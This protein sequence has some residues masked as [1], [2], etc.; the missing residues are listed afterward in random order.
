MVNL[1]SLVASTVAQPSGWWAAIYN[2]IEG[3]IVNY[4]WTILVFTVFVRLIMLPLDFY[5]RYSSR[6]NNFIQKR[7]AGQVQRINEKNKNNQQKAN[8]EVQA[9]YKKEGYNMVGTC[10]FSII[11]IV[12][13]LFVFISFFNTLRDISAYKMV[14]QYTILN[15]T[16][17]EC[18]EAGYSTEQTNETLVQKYNEITKNNQWLWVNNVWKNDSSVSIVPNYNALKD[19]TSSASDKKYKNTYF[20][21]ESELF[22]TEEQYNK[23]M[24]PV[25]EAHKG[26]NGYFILPVL[27]GVFAFLSQFL[28]DLSNKSKKAKQ[29]NVQTQTEAQMQGTMKV[30]KLILPIISVIF[31]ITNPAAFG[32]YLIASSLMG[33]ITNLLIGIIVN[34]MT[35]KEEQKYLDYL[36]KEALYQLKHKKQNKPTMVNYKQIGGSLK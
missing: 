15:T 36:E 31:A 32:I 20:N 17:N 2:W 10:V 18:Q 33:I 30:M 26:W 35:Q 29:I 21:E 25:I 12:V 34:K 9:L 11:N 27:A 16:Y 13:T 8:Q 1:T 5:N 22:I 24:T 14:E 4:G 3:F 19:A 23:V 7:L 6:K 28:S